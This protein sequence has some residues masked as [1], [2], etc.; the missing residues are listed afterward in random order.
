MAFKIWSHYKRDKCKK[1]DDRLTDK[2][3][4]VIITKAEGINEKYFIQRYKG[5]KCSSVNI[6]SNWAVVSK[7]WANIKLKKEKL[8]VL[9]SIQD[10]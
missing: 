9:Q 7:K 5:S 1:Y 10:Y 2:K 3:V 6:S 8:M 4:G